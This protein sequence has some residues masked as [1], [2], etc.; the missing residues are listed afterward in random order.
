[1]K[2]S[3][4]LNMLL[5]W[6]W[7]VDVSEKILIIYKKNDKP[8]KISLDHILARSKDLQTFQYGYDVSHETKTNY[9]LDLSLIIR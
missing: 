2:T 1:M 4:A 7:A 9:E 6:G 3:Y 5:F 8:F